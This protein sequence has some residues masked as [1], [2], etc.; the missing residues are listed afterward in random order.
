MLRIASRAWHMH[1]L[2]VSGEQGEALFTASWRPGLPTGSWTVHRGS[3]PF[4]TLRCKAFAPLHKCFVDLNDETFVLQN[5]LAFS[6]ITEVRGGPFD[7]ATLSGD[8]LDRKFSIE[9]GGRPVAI[10]EGK[11]LSMH[12]THVVHLVAGGDPRIEQ[13]AALLMIDLL[14]QRRSEM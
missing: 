14:I 8:L 3:E 7:G 2:V 9:H 12:Q 6:R 5:R 1:E 10:A 13:L 4:A 11:T